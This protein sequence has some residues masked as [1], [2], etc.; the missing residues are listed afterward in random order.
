[1]DTAIVVPESAHAIQASMGKTADLIFV[2][3]HVVDV[4]LS[5]EILKTS[6]ELT[7]VARQLMGT[8]QQDTLVA[9]FP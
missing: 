7:S 2:L 4:S 3:Q 1:M 6:D 8:A 9:I 5:K